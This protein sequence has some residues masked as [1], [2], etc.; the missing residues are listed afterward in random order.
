MR[1]SPE[2]SPPGTV[3]I[4]VM[5]HGIRES[6]KPVTMLR[7][8]RSSTNFINMQISGFQTITTAQLIQFRAECGHPW[9]SMVMIIDD[10]APAR[11]KPFYPVLKRTDGRQQAGHWIQMRRLEGWR[12]APRAC[13]MS[14]HGLQRYHPE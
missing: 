9:R 1:W 6:G 4:P 3:V 12:L 2:G 7:S 10:G 14:N 11:W 8:Q 13:W 5:F